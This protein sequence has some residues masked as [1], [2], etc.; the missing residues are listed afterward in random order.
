MH[1]F[2]YVIWSNSNSMR[3]E[4]DFWTETTQRQVCLV[5]LDF[6]VRNLKQLIEKSSWMDVESILSDLA[7]WVASYWLIFLEQSIAS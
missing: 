7:Q 6:S 2:E 3:A 4:L 5:E 1:T